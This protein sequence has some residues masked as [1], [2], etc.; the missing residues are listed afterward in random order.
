MQDPV[1]TVDRQVWRDGGLSDGTRAIPEE[2][3]IALTYNGGTYAVM[4]A[5]P[6]DLA[7]FAVGFSLSEG[8][9]QTAGEIES[10]DVVD[11]EDLRGI[12]VQACLAQVREREGVDRL[13]AGGQL[14]LAHVER[15]AQVADDVLGARELVVGGGDVVVAHGHGGLVQEAAGAVVEHHDQLAGGGGQNRACTV[16]VGGV[17]RGVCAH[18]SSLTPGRVE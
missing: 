1:R 5:T 12:L 10:L 11:L 13:Q 16:G 17:G 9:V 3:A 18:V 15:V 14:A 2:T 7:D 4:M 6:Q 8:V